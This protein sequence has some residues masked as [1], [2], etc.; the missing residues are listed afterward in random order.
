MVNGLVNYSLWLNTIQTLTLFNVRKTVNTCGS[1][2]RL[3]EA[4]ITHWH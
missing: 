4:G 3:T 1:G 2:E